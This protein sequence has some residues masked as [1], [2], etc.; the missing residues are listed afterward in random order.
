MLY[1]I[2]EG[3]SSLRISFNRK[4]FP[5]RMQTHKGKYDKKTNGILT[6]FRRPINC[7]VIFPKKNL[8]SVKKLCEE[9]KINAEFYVGKKI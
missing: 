9:F 5:Y 1:S 8:E 7:V 6:E 2:P 4:L 3:N